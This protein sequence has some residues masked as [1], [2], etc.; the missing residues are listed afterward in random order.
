MRDASHPAVT[1]TSE[2]NRPDC[3][4]LLPWPYVQL[5]RHVN[6]WGS[7]YPWRWI[8]E[9]SGMERER[10]E[11]SPGQQDADSEAKKETGFCFLL[12]L[13]KRPGGARDGASIASSSRVLWPRFLSLSTAYAGLV[14]SGSGGWSKKISS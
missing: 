2:Q 7:M 9:A 4:L 5:A 11:A 1:L 8:T 6:R 13:P 14:G 3:L 12:E 10:E